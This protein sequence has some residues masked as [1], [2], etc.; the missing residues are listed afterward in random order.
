MKSITLIA[1]IISF[2]MFINYVCIINSMNEKTSESI[3]WSVISVAIGYGIVMFSPLAYKE[4]MWIGIKML[5]TGCVLLIAG[6]AAFEF[7]NRRKHGDHGVNNML[8]HN[9]E[10]Y[11]W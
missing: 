8:R 7:F 4:S 11:D 6:Y 2:P 5:G 3:R 10:G 1:A 9:D